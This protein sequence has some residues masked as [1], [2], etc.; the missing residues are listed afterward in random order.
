MRP[1]KGGGCLWGVFVSFRMHLRAHCVCVC[2]CVRARVR[3]LVRDAGRG[4]VWAEEEAWD[5]VGGS[6]WR[7]RSFTESVQAH[8]VGSVQRGTS[9]LWSVGHRARAA[10]TEPLQVA[11]WSEERGTP[12]CGMWSV[13]HH[14][15]RG[16]PLCGTQPPQVALWSKERGSPSVWHHQRATPLCAHCVA[17]MI[18]DDRARQFRSPISLLVHPG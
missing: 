13:Q 11:Q 7:A 2:V 1:S 15:E 10:S 12:L 4:P 18:R 9:H 16:T 17:H 5:A 14:R 8:T 3:A 6:V